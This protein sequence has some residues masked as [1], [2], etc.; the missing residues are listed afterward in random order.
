MKL[1]TVLLG[2]A[3]LI[4]G[5]ALADSLETLRSE[6]SRIAETVGEGVG[7]SIA[8][9]GEPPIDLI[10]GDRS[11]PMMSTVKT[12]VSMAALDR[13]SEG[14]MTLESQITI[15]EDDLSVMSPVNLTFPQAPTTTTLYNLI[16]TAIVDSDNTT[17]N[18]MMRVMGG[19]ESVEAFVREQGVDEIS[20]ARNLNGLFVDVYEFDDFDEVVDFFD[21]KATEPGG[22]MGFFIRPIESPLWDDPRDTTTPNAMARLLS[23]FLAGDVLDEERTAILIDI[24]EQTRTGKARLQGMLPPGTIVGHKTGTGHD[25]INDAGW[26]RLPDGRTMVIAVYNRN[27]A[28]IEAKEQV[29]AQIARA[30]YDWALYAEE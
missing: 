5:P 22:V 10:N 25:S 12:L 2:V 6:V 4:S 29:I 3:M 26:I 7:A 28:S 16:W 17:P 19:P 13:V 8:F 18:T 23:G 21:E 14:E 27:T 30:A 1:K 24:M 11:F 20:V 9:P 15:M